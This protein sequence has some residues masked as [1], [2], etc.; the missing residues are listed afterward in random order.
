MLIN[1]HKKDNLTTQ[2]FFRNIDNYFIIK[3]VQPTQANIINMKSIN[4]I[5][6]GI[7]L[8]LILMASCKKKTTEYQPLELSPVQY[9]NT[10]DV[11]I[12]Y[13]TIGSGYPLLLT[14]G[15]SGTMDMWP[16]A[17]LQSLAKTYQVIIYDNRGMGLSTIINDTTFTIKLFARDASRLL[18]ALK[19]QKAH[20][21]G[22]SMGTYVTQEFALDYPALVNKVVLFASD[23]GD[24]LAIPPLPWADSI[25]KKQDVSFKEY[26]TV[27]F[28]PEWLVRPDALKYFPTITEPQIETSKQRQYTAMQLWFAQGGGTSGRLKSFGKR[29]LLLSGMEDVLTPPPN[30]LIMAVLIP[31]ASLVQIEGGG[32]GAIYQFP[33][34]F[35]NYVLTFLTNQN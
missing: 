16:L 24:T 8:A 4:Y 3:Q 18:Q 14:M 26:L 28:P 31:G 29:T 35:S 27:L 10:G 34:D 21:M 32:H 7:L 12:A 1:D 13:R 25:L 19:I 9:A 11:N 33:Y 6:A 15:Y 22:W 2:I 23:C 17:L 5:L 20:A 30:G